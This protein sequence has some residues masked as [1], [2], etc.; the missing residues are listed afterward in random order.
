MPGAPMDKKKTRREHALT[1]WATA[2]L[3]ER[4]TEEAEREGRSVS[5]LLA[6]IAGEW[7]D[8]RDGKKEPAGKN[9]ADRELTRRTAQRPS[10]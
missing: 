3:R 1:L 10:D 2:E 6:R 5:G 8:G 7:L 4:L 9:T